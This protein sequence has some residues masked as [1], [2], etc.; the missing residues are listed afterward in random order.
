MRHAT[1]PS[2]VMGKS[3]SQ[4]IRVLT[5]ERD[6]LFTERI[7]RT[8]GGDERIEVIGGARG[9]EEAVALAV[10]LMPDLI[11]MDIDIAA[12]EGIE[13]THRICEG[14]PSVPVLT[15]GTFETP[16]QIDLAL[17]A[18]AAGL[19]RNEACYSADLTAPVFGLAVM[20]PHVCRSGQPKADR[21]APH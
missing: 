7:M 3:P 18:G 8:L 15:V 11:L 16:R 1:Y 4:A 17:D 10:S 14:V 21:H 13:A 2:M 19:V 12:V 9:G 5:A 20:A 6:R